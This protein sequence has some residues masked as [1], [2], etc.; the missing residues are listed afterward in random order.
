MQLVSIG[1]P[2]HNGAKYLRRAIDSLLC[3]TFRD[4]ELIVSDNGSNDETW[5]I[6][7]EYEAIDKR[8]QLHKQIHN[9][10]AENNFSF[11]LQKATGAYFMWA[12]CDDWWDPEFIR[13]LA[14]GLDTHPKHGV[15]MCSVHRVNEDGTLVDKVIYA[16]K[17]ALTNMSY[18]EVFRRMAK[19]HSSPPIH[20]FIYGLFRTGFIKAVLIQPIQKSIAADRILMSE[21]AL[22]IHF[23]SNPNVLHIR[24]VSRLS[25]SERYAEENIGQVWNDDLRE[26]KYMFLFLMRLISSRNIPISRKLVEIPFP[27]LKMAWRRRKIIANSLLYRFSAQK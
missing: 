5:S 3:Q 17:D 20:L 26:M 23:Y 2:V 14:E 18:R 7:K 25:L 1:M 11:V 9:I 27:W 15:A 16:G 24:T 12:A 10:G 8:I 21:V 13:Q 22:A 4:F 6:L 19:I